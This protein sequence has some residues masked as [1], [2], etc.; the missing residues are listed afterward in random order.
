MSS[1]ISL[2]LT[3]YINLSTA[4]AGDPA[5]KYAGMPNRPLTP[6]SCRSKT[7][8]NITILGKPSKEGLEQGSFALDQR[9]NL[10]RLGK[11][12][13]SG[14]MCKKRRQDGLEGERRRECA[15]QMLPCRGVLWRRL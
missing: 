4:G 8:D 14:E 2:A 7:V 11:V 10:W 1:K 9:T 15:E 3:F 13:D 5:R 6:Q 12:V